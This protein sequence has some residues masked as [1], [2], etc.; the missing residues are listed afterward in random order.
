MTEEKRPVH[1]ELARNKEFELLL[2]VC[3]AHLRLLQLLDI[4][5]SEFRMID[6]DREFVDLPGE[7][8]G[9]LVVTV[10]DR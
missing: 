7:V 5:R 4:R 10:V 8:E 6:G 1:I 9:D 2:R 3:G